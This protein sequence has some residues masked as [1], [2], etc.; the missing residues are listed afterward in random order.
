[1]LAASE[2]D[3]AGAVTEARRALD[4][5]E[6]YV[7][8]FERGR[9]LLALGSALRSSH[10]KAPARTTLEDALAIFDELGAR[11]WAE[12]TRAELG[13]ISGRRPAA[14][15]DLTEA[16]HQVASLAASGHSNKQIAASLHMAVSTVEAH[17]SRV[18][19]KLDVHRAELATRL[20]AMDADRN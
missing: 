2:G 12:K 10:Q 4:E 9:V 5:L 7:Y 20:S 19:R 11:L 18:Y 3:L 13:R 1:M 17:L 8:P 6:G 16:E 15:D 14:S